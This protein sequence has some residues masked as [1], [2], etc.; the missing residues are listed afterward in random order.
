MNDTRAAL[1]EAYGAVAPLLSS[2]ELRAKWETESSLQAFSV[3]GLAGH[4]VRQGEGVV[5]YL[6]DPEPFDD[7]VPA[8]AYYTSVLA[9]MD[10]DAHAQVRERGE[11]MA[12]EGPDALVT[13]HA[14]A[15][16]RLE[17]ALVGSPP[18]RLVR[19]FRGVVMRIDDYVITRL[20]EILVHA[21]DLAVSLG[22]PRPSFAGTAIEL[23]IGHLVDVARLQHDD[24]A[25]LIALTRRERDT[26]D[27]LRVFG[28]ISET[29][30][31]R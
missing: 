11:A 25:V 26:R 31:A 28:P 17:A 21:D 24:F 13:R 27:A 20:V 14:L 19:V 5:T 29:G 8:G 1:V 15:A 7:P 16:K 23:A 2:A 9:G 4:L 30:K 10:A 3:K 6:D 18:D 22:V 12:G